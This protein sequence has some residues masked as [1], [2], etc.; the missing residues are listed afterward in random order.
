MGHLQSASWRGTPWCTTVRRSG[1]VVFG[2]LL[3]ALYVGAR[4]SSAQPIQVLLQGRFAA[5]IDQTGF[6]NLPVLFS[7]PAS[8]V[9]ASFVGD[10]VNATVSALPPTQ[11]SSGLVRFA[12]Y[13][14]QRQISVEA[15]NS[16]SMDILWG[17]AGLG[18]GRH[19]RSPVG[20]ISRAAANGHR[21]GPLT[22]CCCF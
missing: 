4:Y 18:P 7:W 22:S 1:A 10:S 19:L 13:V 6:A 9:H 16:T 2:L 15:T 11:T 3:I 14:D 5:N 21:K 20:C 12:F 17:T 8:S